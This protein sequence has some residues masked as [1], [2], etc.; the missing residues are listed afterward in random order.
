M[1]DTFWKRKPIMRMRLKTLA[2]WT[3]VMSMLLELGVSA[4]GQQLPKA[5][6]NPNVINRFESSDHTYA[7]A[8][9]D[10]RVNLIRSLS[11]LSKSLKTAKTAEEKTKTKALLS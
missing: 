6:A 4:Q 1:N 7:V 2:I 3:L 10:S 5:S 8:A 11:E 9:D